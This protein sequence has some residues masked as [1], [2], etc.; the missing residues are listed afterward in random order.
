[1]PAERGQ[2]RGKQCHP[3]PALLGN[4]AARVAQSIGQR[5]GLGGIDPGDRRF[6]PAGLRDHDVGRRRRVVRGSRSRDHGGVDAQ[7][8]RG[9]PSETSKV[10]RA[11][12]PARPRE[13][14]DERGV[15]GGIVNH[16]Q[17]GDDVGYLRQRQEPTQPHDFDGKAHLQQGGMQGWDVR[18]GS[19]Q[20]RAF[21]RRG[22]GIDDVAQPSGQPS[23]LRIPRGMQSHL[24]LPALGNGRRRLQL[25]DAVPLPQRSGHRIGQAQ[26]PPPA[27]LVHR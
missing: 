22:A 20:H 4:A 19:H 24:C 26:Q 17:R 25:H 12:A 11:D 6:E 3:L 15:R 9:A 10:A 2:L 7:Q 14:P 16:P 27:P 21:P 13:Q 1:M 18:P 23:H 8:G 5:H